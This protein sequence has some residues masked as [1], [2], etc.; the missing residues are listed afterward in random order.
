MGQYNPLSIEFEDR[1]PIP[2]EDYQECI[3]MNLKHVKALEK[4]YADRQQ[5]GGM[6]IGEMKIRN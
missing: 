4:Q 2:E 3:Q 5:N 1:D 6:F